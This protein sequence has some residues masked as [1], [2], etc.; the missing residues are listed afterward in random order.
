MPKKKPAK[1]SKKQDDQPV[2]PL[3]AAPVPEPAAPAPA[4]T[5]DARG[6]L[7]SR[8]W[9][10]SAIHPQ[11]PG[12][13]YPARACAVSSSAMDDLERG[14]RAKPDQREEQFLRLRGKI[15]QCASR[16]FEAGEFEGNPPGIILRSMDFRT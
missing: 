5:R 1:P 13:A 9:R 8:R 6:I 15:E 4:D 3:D 7:R 12:A 2:L 11:C 14:P 10:L 16:K